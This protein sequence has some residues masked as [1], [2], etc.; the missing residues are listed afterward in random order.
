MLSTATG[1]SAVDV[2]PT[3]FAAL[4][5]AEH[6]ALVAFVSL[7]QA[8]QEILVHGDPDRLAAIAPEKSAQIDLLTRLGQKRDRYLT[9]Q[10]LAMSAAGVETWLSRHPAIAVATRRTW[11]ESLRRAETARQLNLSNGLL[12]ES[13][14]QQ[15][16]QKISVLQTA[17]G[18]D[19]VYRPDGHL[20]P[21]RSGRAISQV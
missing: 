19:N 10:N 14:M 6:D 8:E 17:V 4:L 20:G 9:E 13:K 5:Q 3:V 12:I 15:N 18:S 1:D 2:N 16:R 11:R 21:F 7:L